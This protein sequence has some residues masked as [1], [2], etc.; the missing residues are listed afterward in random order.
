MHK[1]FLWGNMREREH[2]EEEGVDGRIKLKLIFKKWNGGI[3][4]IDL[5]QDR[6]RYTAFVNSIM[7]LR[8][9]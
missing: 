8:V 2:L 1:G 9:P 7:K 5:T 4:W 3:D 6:E